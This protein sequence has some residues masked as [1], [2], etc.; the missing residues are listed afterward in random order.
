M[1]QQGFTRRNGHHRSEDVVGVVFQQPIGV[2]DVRLDVKQLVWG[3]STMKNFR[4]KV[5]LDKAPAALLMAYGGE[6]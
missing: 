6:K 3:L 1:G 5:L 2:F 4:I